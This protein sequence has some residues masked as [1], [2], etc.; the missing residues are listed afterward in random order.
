MIENKK[1]TDVNVAREVHEQE[2]EASW[3]FTLTFCVN[4]VKLFESS[5]ILACPNY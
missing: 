5:N 3:T 1:K 4:F 2:T